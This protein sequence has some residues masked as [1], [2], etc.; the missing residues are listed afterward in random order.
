MQEINLFSVTKFILKFN[1]NCIMQMQPSYI[2]K[3]ALYKRHMCGESRGTSDFM[4]RYG[5]EINFE[6]NI[7]QHI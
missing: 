7:F 5:A 4:N 3:V 2:I 1:L 6:Y